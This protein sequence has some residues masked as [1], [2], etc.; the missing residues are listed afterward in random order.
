MPNNLTDLVFG[1]IASPWVFLAGSIVFIL[2]SVAA[3]RMGSSRVSNVGIV[4]GVFCLAIAA[5]LWRLSKLGG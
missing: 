4:M 1:F 5:I 3:E 2:T